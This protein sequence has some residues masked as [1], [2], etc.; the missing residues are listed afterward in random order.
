MDAG[1]KRASVASRG[2]GIE[3]KSIDIA[4]SLVCTKNITLRYP[5][6]YEEVVSGSILA[7]FLGILLSV[8]GP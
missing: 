2:E 7:I 3:K 1:T 6:I 4:V 8:R 5:K